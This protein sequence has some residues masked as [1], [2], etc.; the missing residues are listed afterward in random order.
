VSELGA[1]RFT[2]TLDPADAYL[3]ADQAQRVPVLADGGF[4]EVSGL[5]AELE[6]LA[7]SEGGTNGFLHQLPVRHSW[8]R[9]SL[10]HG[11]VRGQGLWDWYRAGLTQSLGA[12][13][14]GSIMLR[15]PDGRLAFS[16]VFWAGL[17]AKWNGPSFHAMQSEIA[18]EGLEIAHQGIEQAQHFEG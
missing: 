10:K 14:N 13:R 15:A 16:W 12:R 1:Y 18:I 8:G 7:Y 3:P 5:G 6:I 11:I 2:V 9:I 17:A 4:Q